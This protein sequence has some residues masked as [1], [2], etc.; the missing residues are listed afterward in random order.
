[1]AVPGHDS[2]VV[3]SEYSDALDATIAGL[4]RG[5]GSGGNAVNIVG[6]DDIDGVAPEVQLRVA[7]LSAEIAI[8]PAIRRS[9]DLTSIVGWAEPCPPWLERVGAG[10]G[11]KP[12]TPAEVADH[13]RDHLSSPRCAASPKFRWAS[14]SKP[15]SYGFR[16][17]WALASPGAGAL[18]RQEVGCGSGK[19]SGCHG[20]QQPR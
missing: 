2:Q 19:H 15:F 1:V 7:P 16:R 8:R 11:I 9:D 17:A 4:R 5:P 14:T 3:A 12:G 10:G 13:G 6:Y 18:H 20:D